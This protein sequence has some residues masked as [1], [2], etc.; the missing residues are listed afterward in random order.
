MPAQRSPGLAQ[1]AVKDNSIMITGWKVVK[2]KR[3]LFTSVNV[4]PCFDYC[5]LHGLD[6]KIVKAIYNN[7]IIIN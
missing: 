7:Q 2:E 4:L 3:V 1:L 6:T 5:V